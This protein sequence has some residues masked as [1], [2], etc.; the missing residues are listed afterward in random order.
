MS[1]PA[2]PCKPQHTRFYTVWVNRVVLTVVRS[3]PVYPDKRTSSDR[4]G[5]SGWCQQRT[6]AVPVSRIVRVADLKPRYALLSQM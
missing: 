5:M 6:K 1:Q 2:A 3:L 4:P